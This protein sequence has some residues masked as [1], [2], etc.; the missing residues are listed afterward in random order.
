[1]K[2][3]IPNFHV[4]ICNF[5]SEEEVKGWE[6]KDNPQFFDCYWL[7]IKCR[8]AYIYI[9]IYNVWNNSLGNTWIIIIGEF[10]KEEKKIW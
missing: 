3:K 9:Y 5:Q 1:L 4:K 6:I 7:L 8:N 2:D 10:E